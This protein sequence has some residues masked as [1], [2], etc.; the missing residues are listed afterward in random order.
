MLSTNRQQTGHLNSSSQLNPNNRTSK[1]LPLTY[2]GKL[3]HRVHDYF[4]FDLELPEVKREHNPAAR[5]THRLAVVQKVQSFLKV[6]DERQRPWKRDL[7]GSMF[8]L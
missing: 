8:F 1:A 7:D 2:A 3:A 6:T 5:D 4:R